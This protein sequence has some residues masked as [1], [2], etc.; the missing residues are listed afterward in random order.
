[1]AVA[2]HGN[3]ANAADRLAISRP[4]VSKT[5]SQLEHTLG[6]P[7]FD[8]SPQGVEPTLYGRA[9]LKRGVAIFDELRQSVKEIEFLVDPTS[10]ELRLGCADFMAGIVGVAIDRMSRR[11]SRIVFEVVST[12]W[13]QESRAMNFHFAHESSNSRSLRSVFQ[14]LPR[15]DRASRLPQPCLKGSCPNFSATLTTT[16]ALDRRKTDNC[17][18]AIDVGFW[19][20]L[21]QKSARGGLGA[22]IES[23]RASL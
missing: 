15:A 17:C 20:I 18:I 4:V 10:G 13:R 23:Q 8:R 19:P 2:E 11:Y 3:M 16:T 6:V 5:I 7:L 21:L 9:L 22:T 14:T 1:M 12:G